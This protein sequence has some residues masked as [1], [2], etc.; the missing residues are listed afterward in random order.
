LSQPFCSF[1]TPGISEL[2]D[3]NFMG[4]L[5]VK[6]GRN[7]SRECVSMKRTSEAGQA[8][9]MVALM[10]IVLLSVLGLAI[11][12]G[13]FRYVKRQLQTASDAAAIAGALAIPSC[14]GTPGCSNLVDAAKKASAENGFADGTAGVSVAVHNPPTSA[15]DPHDGDSKYVEVLVSQ[16]EPTRF[17]NMFG[18]NSAT[19]GARGEARASAGNCIYSLTNLDL[20]VA[21][22][23]NSRCGVVVES[24]LNCV[25]GSIT[26]PRIGIGSSGGLT[27]LCST[28]PSPVHIAA[29]TPADPL[30]YLPKPAV[31]ACGTSTTSPYTGHNGQL[32]L[33]NPKDAGPSFVLN[34]GNY[35]GGIVIGNVT[36]VQVTFTGSTTEPYVLTSTS[37][38][39]GGLTITTVLGNTVTGS[40]VTFY[41]NGPAGGITF[42]GGGVNLSAPTSGT[43]EGI[44][45]FQNASNTASATFLGTILSSSTLTGSYYFP[46]ADLSFAA[47]LGLNAAYTILV[48]NNIHFTAT[49][50]FTIKNDYSS[51][52]DG[53]PIKDSAALVE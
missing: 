16:P 15:G 33:P 20:L 35:C 18:V 26:A 43:Y 30:A 44:L 21:L 31:P 25:G 6:T 4:L 41:N 2:A 52:A 12:M 51:L 10:L 32:L 13:Y 24:N 34:P 28:N 9:V 50:G 40:N 17:A 7:R 27:L 39:D 45:F 47:D 29:P 48:A 37:G 36:P 42:G 22:P 46:G 3:T 5:Q 53:S 19:L 1:P 8:L 14:G 11:D 23:L 49:I 38:A